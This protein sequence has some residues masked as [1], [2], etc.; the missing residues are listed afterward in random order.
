MTRSWI[1]AEE[2]AAPGAF[3]VFEQQPSKNARNTGNLDS[4]CGKHPAA[5]F[6]FSFL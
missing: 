3:H 5:G 2:R 6:T 1:Q 4:R